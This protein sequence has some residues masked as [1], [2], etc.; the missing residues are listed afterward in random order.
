MLSVFV[1]SVVRTTYRLRHKSARLKE[2]DDGLL[3]AVIGEPAC[4]RI[5]AVFT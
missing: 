4:A 2:L 3:S 1:Q 5:A